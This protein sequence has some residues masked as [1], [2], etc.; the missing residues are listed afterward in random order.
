MGTIIVCRWGKQNPD[1]FKGIDG[2][3]FIAVDEEGEI[4]SAHY[5]TN[6][7]W[8][9]YDLV[10]PSHDNHRKKYA[11]RYPE[12]Y[13]IDVQVD[14]EYNEIFPEKTLCTKDYSP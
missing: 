8:A 5:C 11:K 14:K 9:I 6:E 3:Q 4:V 7:G 2:S 12:G 1:I 13:Q 10:K